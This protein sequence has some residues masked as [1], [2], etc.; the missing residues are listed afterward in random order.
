MWYQELSKITEVQNFTK[1]GY[2]YFFL[3]S[4]C[5]NT[6]FPLLSKRTECVILKLIN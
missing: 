5:P 3:V 4:Y 2:E 6:M 1:P